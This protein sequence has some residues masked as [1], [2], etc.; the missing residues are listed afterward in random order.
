[1]STHFYLFTFSFDLHSVFHYFAFSRS[2]TVFVPGAG[3]FPR[4]PR[5][6]SSFTHLNPRRGA[7]IAQSGSTLTIAATSSTAR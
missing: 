1:M 5:Q 2:R 3:A 4:L 6:E 7:P